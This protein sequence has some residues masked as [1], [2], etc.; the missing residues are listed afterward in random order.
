MVIEKSPLALLKSWSDEFESTSNRVRLLIGG[1]HWLSDGKHKESILINF[2]KKYTFNRYHFSAGFI[3]SQDKASPSSGEIDILVASRQ[4]S[5]PWHNE[6]GLLIVSPE[7]VVAH[8]HVKSS[9]NKSAIEDI[10]NSIKMANK[11]ISKGDSNSLHTNVWSAAF[12]FNES[13]IPS[14][15][16][17]EK[18]I[19]DCAKEFSDFTHLPKGIF[20]NPD[21]A[22][23]FNS[24]ISEVKINII[25]A[26]SLI[27][28]LFLCYFHESLNGAQNSEIGDLLYSLPAHESHYFTIKN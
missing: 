19:T 12:F 14:N 9:Y 22:I 1:S 24:N 28:A 2:L 4:S 8:I 20:I 5:I 16:L 11:A 6:E 10:F 23:L 15:K 13:P 18:H 21:I 7:C 26:E 3:V 27:V 17:L 25:K